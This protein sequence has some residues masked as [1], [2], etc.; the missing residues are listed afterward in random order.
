[1]MRQQVERHMKHKNRVVIVTL[2]VLIFTMFIISMNTG[3]IRLSPFEVLQ[4][5]FWQ[6]TAQ[7]Q[8]ILYEFRLPRIIIAILVGC[9][10][11]VAGAVLQ[12]ITRNPLADPGIIG[13]NAGAGLMVLLFVT[14][15]PRDELASFF[16]MPL[17]AFIGA[18]AAAIMIYALSYKKNEGI[19]AVRLLLNGIGVAAGISAVTIVL[20]IVITPEEYQIV[21]T[22]M[23]G[24]I[25]GSTWNYVIA[26]LPWLIVLL[27]LV[28]QK[29][30]VLNVL[31]L[32]ELSAVSLGV[33]IEKERR[34]LLFL[35]VGL[36]AAS[37]SVSGGIGFVGLIAPHVARRLVGGNF[38]ALLP[39]SALL[40][41]LLVLAADTL[42]RSLFA[43]TEIPAGIVVAVIG[44]PYFLYLLKKS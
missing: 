32:N 36:A 26:V 19:T 43:P 42:G 38:K 39:V 21:A 20:T 12:G 4:T 33:H 3:S 6:G 15:A 11:A 27:P 28:F 2:V 31:T 14:L 37:V 8:L 44:A 17:L 1:M 9:G 41:A 34:Y 30:N 24:S 35:A 16:M 25:W 13:I 18:G 29:A 7:Q 22:W 5:L 23:A 40:G 10:L